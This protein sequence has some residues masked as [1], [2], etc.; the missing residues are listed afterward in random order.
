MNQAGLAG[1][2][3]AAN[4]W[5]SRTARPETSSG[6]TRVVI[7]PSRQIAALDRRIFGSFLEQLGRAIYT[8]I[9]EPGLEIRRLQ[10]IP[11]RRDERNS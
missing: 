1:L 6:T 3:V 4:G 7:D 9:Y 8:G 11:H 2:A 5:L 10:R